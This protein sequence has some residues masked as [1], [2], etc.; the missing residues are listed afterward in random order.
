[1]ER[2]ELKNKTRGTKKNFRTRFRNSKTAKEKGTLVPFKIV[3]TEKGV[4]LKEQK[5]EGVSSG[6]S[7]V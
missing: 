1:M 5:T 7:E 4:N 2:F 6:R 3:E